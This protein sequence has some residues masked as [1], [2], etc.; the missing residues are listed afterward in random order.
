M[1]LK[2]DKK[3]V[4]PIKSDVTLQNF[5]Q[6][7]QNSLAALYQAAHV[8]KIVTA[9]PGAND[10]AIGDIYIVTSPAATYLT[11][12]TTTGWVNQ[13][14]GTSSFP[15]PVMIGPQT[16]ANFIATLQSGGSLTAAHTYIY[17]VWAI[18]AN[19]FGSIPAVNQQIVTD[20]SHKTAALSWTAVTGA[21]A[22]HITRSD[23]NP[24]AYDGAWD[25]GTAT[26]FTDNGAVAFSLPY[27]VPAAG[28]YPLI[29]TGFI[30]MPAS[31]GGLRWI[32]FEDGLTSTSG[33]ITL[34]SANE[35]EFCTGVCA[36]GGSNGKYYFDVPD[37]S[38][39]AIQIETAGAY[40]EIV[41][42]PLGSYADG[43]L[44]A[45][46]IHLKIA[47]VDKVLIGAANTDIKNIPKF[48]GTNVT[49]AQTATLG[50]NGPMVTTTPYTWVQVVTADGTTGYIPVWK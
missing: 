41:F 44:N 30:T 47:N 37:A 9:A 28:Q 20:S 38:Q 35:M 22:Y 29:V 26:T 33:F 2:Q 31:T 42:A 3:V 8:H 5:S 23:G 49:G 6:V 48:S 25:A 17:K 4:P 15:T 18:D 7:I 1:P 45:A 50:T 19:G 43:S 16:P 34:T 46:N 36:S 11:I 40:G 32:N 27:P 10:G 39:A 14:L 12:K 24:S 21:V 13:S